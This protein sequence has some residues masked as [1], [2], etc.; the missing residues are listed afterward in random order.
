[1]GV[2]CDASLAWALN[3][4]QGQGAEELTFLEVAVIRL[5]RYHQG[6]VD[7]SFWEEELDGRVGVFPSLVVE[8]LG[9]PL[10]A[11]GRFT[12]WCS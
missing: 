2:L 7:D 11:V 5:L 1:M 3:E 6:E 9:D 10:F 12:L 4:Y 8:L